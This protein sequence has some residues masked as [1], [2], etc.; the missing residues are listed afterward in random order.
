MRSVA[1]TE[2]VDARGAGLIINKE[3]KV[4]LITLPTLKRLR[5]PGDETVKLPKLQRWARDGKIPGAFKQTI[6]SDW[7]V[8]L[9]EFDMATT[10][11]KLASRK[12]IS[13]ENRV[14]QMVM[15]MLSTGKA[16]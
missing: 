3:Y 13:R 4:N 6:D 10:T 16:L 2:N 9:D 14:L 12:Q 11:A 8:D 5:F 1:K 15:D 7:I